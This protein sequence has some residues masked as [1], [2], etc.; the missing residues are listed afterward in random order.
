MDIVE[1]ALAGDLSELTM[2]SVAKRLGVSILHFIAT[3]R[4]V[5]RCCGLVRI[6][7]CVRLYGRTRIV[8]GVSF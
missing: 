1:A 3:S 6:T 5:K 2:P 7:L 8:R 4:T